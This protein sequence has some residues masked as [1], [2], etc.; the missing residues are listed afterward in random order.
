MTIKNETA[1][2]TATESWE[3]YWIA[4][5]KE[6]EVLGHSLYVLCGS[7]AYAGRVIG[8]E[9][10]AFVVLEG[11]KWVFETGDFSKQTWDSAEAPQS[12]IWRFAIDKVE[13]F[14]NLGRKF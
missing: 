13:S 6:C 11:A 7:Y 12:G 4:R 2:E 1:I 3:Q 5:S 9:K 10:D 8:V 14:G